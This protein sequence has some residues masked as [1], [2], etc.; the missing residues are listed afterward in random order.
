VITFSSPQDSKHSD[1]YSANKYHAGIDK[2]HISNTPPSSENMQR[3]I[4]PAYGSWFS[5]RLAGKKR[6][7]L[8]FTCLPEVVLV[9]EMDEVFDP[10]Y[11]GL[12]GSKTVMTIAYKL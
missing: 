12:C 5:Y 7:H 9:I 10:A 2:P 1:V 6:G 11:T 3:L 8:C 4:F